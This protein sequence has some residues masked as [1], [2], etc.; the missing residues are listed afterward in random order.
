M[1]AIVRSRTSGS[2]SC[3][4]KLEKPVAELCLQRL[5][6][7]LQIVAGIKAA[8]DLADLLAERLAVAEVG[9]AGERIDLRAGVVD[10]VFARDR[11]AGRREQVGDGVADDGAAAMADMHRPGRVGGDVL[12]V[13]LLAAAEV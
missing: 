9:R 11:M 1:A 8:R 13:D 2:H 12:D 5:A 10:V 7:R 6:D 4:G 3:C